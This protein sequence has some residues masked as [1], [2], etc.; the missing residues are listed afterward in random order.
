MLTEPQVLRV[1]GA[2]LDKLHGDQSIALGQHAVDTRVSLRVLGSVVQREDQLVLPTVPALAILGIVCERA[3]IPPQRVEELVAEAVAL[4][5]TGE[6]T[7]PYIERA[8][9]AERRAREQMP[10]ATRR[11][12]LN[13]IVEL[14]CLR[15][16]PC[17]PGARTARRRRLATV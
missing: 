6:V 4:L 14:S 17:A 7:S 15:V 1:L 3:G 13:R 10:K 2:E 9:I 8:K 12:P 5:A 16:T 11:G